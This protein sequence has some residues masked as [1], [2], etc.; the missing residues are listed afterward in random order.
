MQKIRPVIFVFAVLALFI[1]LSSLVKPKF[2]LAQDCAANPPVA[3]KVWTSSGPGAG[4]VTLFWSE[5]AYADR[6]AV[7]YG[8]VSGKYIYG[9]DNIGGSSARSYTVKSLQPGQKYVFVVSGARGC[10]ASP[11]SAEVWAKAMNG[12]VTGNQMVSSKNVSSNSVITGSKTGSVQTWGY[13]SG[14][15]GKQKLWAKSGPMVGEVT[16]YWQNTDSADNYHIV[17]GSWPGKYEYGALNIGKNPWYTVKKLQPGKSYYFAIVP[18]MN[19]QAL[20]TSDSVK[21]TAKMPVQV[22]MVNQSA[23]TMM[24]QPIVTPTVPP[25]VEVTPTAAVVQEEVTPTMAPQVD[26]QSTNVNKDDYDP[27]WQPDYPSSNVQGAQTERQGGVQVILEKN[28]EEYNDYNPN[29]VPETQ[30]P[31]E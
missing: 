10:S 5:S 29:W 28:I 19:N 7:A 24:E 13:T 27:N 8:T 16:L 14:P 20:Y 30:Q 21:A 17:Y 23:N 2:V 25:V 26:Q 15:V 1:S 4:Q 22:V 9:A 31:Q 3:P 6:Y 18:V 12:Q 11:F